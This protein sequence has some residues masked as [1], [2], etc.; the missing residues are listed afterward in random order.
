MG[1]KSFFDGRSCEYCKKP[2]TTVLFGHIVCGDDECTEKARDER[3]ACGGKD[4][5]MMSGV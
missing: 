5:D 1:D 2:A 3:V 4:P